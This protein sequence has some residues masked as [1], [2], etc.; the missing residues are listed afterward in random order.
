MINNIFEIIC[1]FTAGKPLSVTWQTPLLQLFIEYLKKSYL[2]APCNQPAAHP[3]KRSQIS[4]NIHTFRTE[5]RLGNFL[6]GPPNFKMIQS[7]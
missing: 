6:F 7:Q 3:P 1:N 4:L 5:I 2:I